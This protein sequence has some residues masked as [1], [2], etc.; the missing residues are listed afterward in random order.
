MSLVWGTPLALLL[1]SLL[2]GPLLAHMIRRMPN[3]RRP[4]GACSIGSRSA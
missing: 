2:V 1:A 4:F 3:E